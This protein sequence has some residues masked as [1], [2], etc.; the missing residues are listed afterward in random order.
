M[1][2]KVLV[3][4]GC[5]QLGSA[6]MYMLRE[7]GIPVVVIDD[8]RRASREPDLAT[9][10][11][12]FS[13]T[14]LLSKVFLA[15]PDIRTVIHAAA[16]V[17]PEESV[18]E[19]VLYYQNNVAKTRVLI[20]FLEHLGIDQ[21][22]FSSSAA[23][24]GDSPELVLSEFQELHPASPYAETKTVTERDLASTSMR[25]ICFRYF[26]PV[27]SA[28]GTV[29]HSL[30]TA[31]KGFKPFWVNG[32]N[33]GTSDGSP[34]R[35]FISVEDL[36]LAHVQAVHHIG[37]L[38]P[39]AIPINLGSGLATPIFRLTKIVE[40]VTGLPVPVRIGA[41][42]EGDIRGGAADIDMARRVLHWKPRVSLEDSVARAWE[43]IK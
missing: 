4:G 43:S 3:T 9:Y 28:P 34:I 24:Y 37:A 22:I 5:G 27:T 39:G 33:W 32:D 31:A 26:N 25:S 41:R 21:F 12:D 1:T 11:G 18:R 13:D 29:L 17:S 23:V 42:R 2:D 6:I 16:Y 15:H 8:L 19:P 40:R 30:F 7:W 38:P 10:I 36:A 14:E 20:S 35:D